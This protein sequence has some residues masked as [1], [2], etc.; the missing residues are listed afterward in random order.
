MASVV[1]IDE[2]EVRHIPHP[3]QFWQLSQ[4]IK[5]KIN[6]IKKKIWVG[7]GLGSLSSH[8]SKLGFLNWYLCLTKFLVFNFMLI[9]SII[10]QLDWLDLVVRLFWRGTIPYEIHGPFRVRV[11]WNLEMFQWPENLPNLDYTNQTIKVGL[12]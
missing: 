5:I 9:C 7:Q 1:K 6:P 10:S 4:K 8:K 12:S 3:I 2:L 11:A